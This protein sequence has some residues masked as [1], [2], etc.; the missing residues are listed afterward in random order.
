MS[1][2]LPKRE[3]LEISGAGFYEQD[4]LPVAQP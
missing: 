1:G 2:E 4:V 3:S